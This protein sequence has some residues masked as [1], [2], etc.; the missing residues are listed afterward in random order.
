[1]L[2]RRGFFKLAAQA[3]L[4]ALAFAGYATGV[5]AM[6][7][8]R[9]Q[10]YSLTP[11]RWPP[12]LKLRIVVLADFHACEPWMTADRMAGICKTANELGGDIILLLGDYAT[13]MKYILDT[14]PAEQIAA[15]LTTL[16][17]PLGV[18]AVLGNHD[19]WADHAWQQAQGGE[20][21]VEKALRAAGIPV[22]INRTVK[23]EKD[24]QP[25]WLGGLGDQM[26]LKQDPSVG[27]YEPIGIEDMAAV[28]APVDDDAPVV[29][30]AHEPYVIPVLPE[31]ISLTICGHTH[32]GQ[33][34]V[35]GWRPF[36]RTPDEKRYFEGHV[37]D[38]GRH[39]VISRGLG[40]SGL[41]MRVGVWPEIMV[42]EIG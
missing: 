8:P 36:L 9:I 17:A 20:T 15:V 18:H 39:A 23:L 31:R 40:C 38:K 41:P 2:T 42:L 32:G 16:Q 21:V 33:M 4:T 10:R 3:W 13:S 27:R 28:M 29:L 26:A 22:Y 19:Y 37:V 30:M 1:M 11:P 34:N 35:L 12:G 6:G 5:E 14:V 25:F 7:T 24:G